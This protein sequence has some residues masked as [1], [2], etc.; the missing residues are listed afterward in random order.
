MKQ[1]QLDHSHHSP[2]CIQFPLCLFVADVTHAENVG[3]LFRIADALGVE[4]IYLHGKTPS[5]PD[6][7]LRKTSR[8]TDNAVPY[9]VV[10]DAMA[11]IQSLKHDGYSIISLELTTSS[12]SLDELMLPDKS[13]VCLIVGAENAGVSQHLLNASDYVV[14]I[15][16]LGQNSSMNV[17]MACAITSYTLTRQLSAL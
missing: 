5:P 9:S 17:A 7:K 4:H 8:A 2:S 1:T 11:V 16:M 3:S 13:K 10:D 6:K 14:H 12:I 15:P